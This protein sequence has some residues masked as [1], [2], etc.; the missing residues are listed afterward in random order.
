MHILYQ[1]QMCVPI[2]DIEKS[3]QNKYDYFVFVSTVNV[4]S[5][6]YFIHIIAPSRLV[7]LAS[8][9]F[10]TTCFAPLLT[11]NLLRFHFRCGCLS[12]PDWR[13]VLLPGFVSGDAPFQ[14]TRTRA[15]K[16]TRSLCTHRIDFHNTHQPPNRVHYFCITIDYIASNTC[17]YC[18]R[19]GV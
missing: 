13:I 2:I 5:D 3:C 11:F 12:I 16:Q 18:V 15:R 9:H 10:V 6:A 14:H 8:T 4:L 1:W 7:E 19:C 17:V